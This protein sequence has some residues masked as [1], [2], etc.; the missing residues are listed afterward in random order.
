MD[1]ACFSLKQPADPQI[2]RE[3][4]LANNICKNFISRK[5]MFGSDHNGVNRIFKQ[6]NPV[7]SFE[8]TNNLLDNDVNGLYIDRDTPTSQQP[9]PG[10]CNTL[11]IEKRCPKY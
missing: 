1:M 9:W 6:Q 3:D 10:F 7:E 4:G 5:I 2:T 8:Y 11:L